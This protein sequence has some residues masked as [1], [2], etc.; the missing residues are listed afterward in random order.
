[1]KPVFDKSNLPLYFP[2]THKSTFIPMKVDIFYYN[3]RKIVALCKF[4]NSDKISLSGLSK[5]EL[6]CGFV[7]S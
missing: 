1:M 5:K 2:N 3:L 7:I 6:S 4:E